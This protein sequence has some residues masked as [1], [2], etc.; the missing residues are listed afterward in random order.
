M[1]PQNK[2]LRT[3]RK[4][5]MLQCS[6]ATAAVLCIL[7]VLNPALNTVVI[8]SLGASSFIAFTMPHANVS[9]PRLLVGGCIVGTIVGA[10]C[11]FL[12]TQPTLSTIPVIHGHLHELF[13]ALSVG[14][15]IFFM[16]MTK[17]AHPPAAGLALG[18]VLNEWNYITVIVIFIGII[19]I[20]CIKYFF[21]DL[22]VNLF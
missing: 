6:M 15:S 21:K 20:S 10:C 11:H 3:Y 16:T 14:V 9:S 1:K 17:T 13:G 18:F 19:L 7:I 8:A 5:C 12:A 22:M 2:D 4:K